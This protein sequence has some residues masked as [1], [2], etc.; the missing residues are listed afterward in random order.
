MNS[1]G[2][3]FDKA[4]APFFDTPIAVEG[5]RP[6]GKRIAGNFK[7]CVF[8]NG[9]A[10]PF[11]AGDADSEIHTFSISIMAGDWLENKPPQVGDKIYVSNPDDC[12]PNL[13]NIVL[14][15]SHIDTIIGDTWVLTAKEIEQ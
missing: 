2:L 7:A 15:V 8:D 14:A 5:Q 12:V 3:D 6:G 4:F 13:P 9:F 11:A 1:F 10:D